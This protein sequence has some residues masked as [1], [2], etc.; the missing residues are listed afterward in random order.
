MIPSSDYYID[1]AHLLREITESRQAINVC[2]MWMS[3]DMRNGKKKHVYYS[4]RI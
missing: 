1:S 3:P 4:H 2:L